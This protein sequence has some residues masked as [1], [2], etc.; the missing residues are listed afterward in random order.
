MSA[1]PIVEREVILDIEGMTCASC[2]DRLER[3]LGRQPSVSEARVSLATRTAAIRSALRDP[4]PLIEAVEKAGY[5]ARVHESRDAPKDEIRDYRRRL[6]VAAFFSFDVL[7][8]SLVAAPGSRASTL[9]AWLFATPVQFYGGWPFLKAAAR[10]A[11]RGVYTMDTLVAAGSLAA[12]GYSIGALL[13]GAHHAYFDTA[14]MIVTLILLGRFLEATARVKAGDAASVLLERQ[15]KQATLLEDGVERPAPIGDLRVGDVV[16][17]RPGEKVPAD[18]RVR[19]GSSSVDLSLLTG[20]SMPL[21]VGP[22]DDVVGASLNGHGR[23]EVELTRVGAD[24]RFAQIVR[25]LEVTQASK[26]PIQRLAD[27]IAAAFVPRV[28]MLPWG[29]SCFSLSSVRVGSAERC[30]E[31][32]LWCS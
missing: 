6:A 26:A 3:V 24:T 14:A 27:R 32:Q 25:L 19:S 21:D 13:S 12:Y 7:V 15:A 31:P 8:F 29:C 5:H 10:A 18:G 20:E 2:V 28:V 11:R 1:R 9:A 23:L 22:G 30:F 4:A 17:V 16:V